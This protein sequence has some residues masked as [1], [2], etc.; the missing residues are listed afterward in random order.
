MS[1]YR[2]RETKVQNYPFKACIN[3][4]VTNV[5]LFS[6]YSIAQ[7]KQQNQNRLTQNSGTF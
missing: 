5:F 3:F 1:E 7:N 4:F 2:E 6:D